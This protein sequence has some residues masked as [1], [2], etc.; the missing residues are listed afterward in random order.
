MSVPSTV[1]DA[2]VGPPR[3]PRE[4]IFN[5]PGIILACCIV[6]I[7][8]HAWRA[9]I[10]V[11][12]DN[13]VVAELAFMPARVSNALHIVPT[14]LAA[15]YNAAVDHNPLMAAQIDFLIGDGHL[16]WWTFITYSL[17]HG[18]WAHVG[19]NC[20]WLVAFGS[21]V[22]R[23][24]T[25]VRFLLL[26]LVAAFAGALAEYLSDVSS[27]QI[28][29]GASAAVSGAMGAA[30]RFV[31]R[32]TDE[33]MRIFEKSRLNEAF[34]QPALTLRQ[35]FTTKAAPGLHPILGSQPTSCSA[36]FPR[37]EGSATDRSR[38]KRISAGFSSAS[39]CFPYSIYAA[40]Q[41]WWWSHRCPRRL[42]NIRTRSLRAIS[43]EGTQQKTSSPRREIV[44]KDFCEIV[45]A[46]RLLQDGTIGMRG[47]NP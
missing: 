19:F 47:G 41:T 37:S 33:P 26:M 16:R 1:D 20:L 10:D 36:I 4:P 40:P 43:P 25:A 32:P 45:H 28:V 21:A 29:I 22:A 9:L 5:M 38:G 15:V 46:K 8:I 3:R 13:Q 6:L 30:T 12:T 17:L 34:R 24:F 23:R 14:R 44:S 27:F 2:P 42:S 31:F 11:E 39:S 7:G 35:T 18:S